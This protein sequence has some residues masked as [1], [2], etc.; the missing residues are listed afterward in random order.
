MR[1]NGSINPEVRHDASLVAYARD[2]LHR[3]AGM[4]GDTSSLALWRRFAYGPTGAPIKG[5]RLG[6]DLIGAAEARLLGRLR[7]S[8][9]HASR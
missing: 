8:H 9:S 1:R 7:D 5:F 2:L 3:V 4:S 6:L